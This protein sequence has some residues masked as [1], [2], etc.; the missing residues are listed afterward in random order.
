M[1][2]QPFVAIVAVAILFLLLLPAG[3]ARAQDDHPE[4]M[5]P[6]PHTVSI[7]RIAPG[8]HVAFLEW[9]AE[10]EAIAKEAGAPPVHW[11]VHMDGDSWDFVTIS[12]DADD[13][14][15]GERIETMT[16]EA[17]LTTG[18]AAGMEIREFIA[19]HTD[20]EAMGPLTAAEI[21][22][23]VRGEN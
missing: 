18:P 15:I 22:A 13:P 4:M 17:G 11:F 9:M 19:V 21:L 12:K 20:T 3:D 14:E 7:Y 10:R 16:R 5:E 23:A 6:S 8:Q 2:R 1:K